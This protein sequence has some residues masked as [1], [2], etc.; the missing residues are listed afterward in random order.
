MAPMTPPLVGPSAAFR[1]LASM[2][3]AA[4][5]VATTLPLLAAPAVSAVTP[6]SA[7]PILYA[8]Y[9]TAGE[10]HL[11]TC[12]PGGE[13][14]P[15]PGTV[16]ARAGR[17]SPDG[18]VIAFN[19]WGD[20]IYLI[21]PDGSGRR[22]IADWSPGEV[23]SE[24][25]WSPDGRRIAYFVLTP[26]NGSQIEIIDSVDGTP[27]RVDTELVQ[28]WEWLDDGTFLGAAWRYAEGGWPRNEELAE[29]APDGTMTF[30]TD[31]PAE[32]EGVPRLSPDGTGSR[33]CRTT[34]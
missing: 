3:A 7:G 1:R 20:G 2:A 12:I 18:R 31:T 30:L 5:M 4:I 16:G 23:F 15:V 24:P 6:G 33:S 10:Q 26:G 25:I 27:E 11:W 34:K 9:N 21:N 13:P 17:W 14:V 28:V 8:Q 29:M 32:D 22:E 19:M